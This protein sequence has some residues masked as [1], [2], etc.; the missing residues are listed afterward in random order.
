MA[1]GGGSP[2]GRMGMGAGDSMEL[3]QRVLLQRFDL[4]GV[5][6]ELLESGRYH[7]YA[8]AG[9]KAG[10]YEIRER[11]AMPYIIVP[12]VEANGKVRGR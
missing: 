10:T 2:W 12:A 9:M 6:R 7:F 5:P 8:K 3:W 1:T 11:P 4:S